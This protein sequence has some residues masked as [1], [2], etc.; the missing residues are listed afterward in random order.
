MTIQKLED[1]KVYCLYF[2]N[3]GVQPINL[4]VQ[5]GLWEAEIIFL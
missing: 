5:N 4:D 3:S 2:E 1:R